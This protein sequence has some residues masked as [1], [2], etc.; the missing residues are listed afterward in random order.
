MLETK[1]LNTSEQISAYSDP[2]RI[3]ILSEF[4][5]L[6]RPATEKEIAD[7]IGDDPKIV[8]YHIKK[9]ESSGILQLIKTKSVNGTTTTYYEP[10]A[11]KFKIERK[12]IND[13]TENEYQTQVEKAVHSTFEYSKSIL[14]TN[15]RNREKYNDEENGSI[16]SVTVQ[17]TPDEMQEFREYVIAFMKKKQVKENN[18]ALSR[19]KQKYHLFFV[20]TLID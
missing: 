16:S 3:K 15:I 1:V 10:S 20:T 5:R 11:K 14:L 7:Y 17:L 2:Y 13:S 12:D 9:L 6:E 4:Y 19:E 8:H 18:E